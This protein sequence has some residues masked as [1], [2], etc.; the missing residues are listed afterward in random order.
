MI[1]MGDTTMLSILLLVVAVAV[2][3]IAFVP[4]PTI[5][6]NEIEEIFKET[7]EHFRSLTTR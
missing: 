4:M 6:W 7:E 1:L 5:Q 2:V 3:V